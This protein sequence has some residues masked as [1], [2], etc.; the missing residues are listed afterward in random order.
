M[1]MKFLNIKF[2]SLDPYHSWNNYLSLPLSLCT[3]I[4]HTA[5]LIKVKVTDIS[6]CQATMWCDRHILNINMEAQG[7]DD[8]TFNV[9]IS[10][11]SLFHKPEHRE[12]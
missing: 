6:R 2:A 3:L 9:T 1:D 12:I 8:I 7:L 10:V 11:F 5:Q 4:H